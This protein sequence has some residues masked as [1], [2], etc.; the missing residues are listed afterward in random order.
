MMELSKEGK[1]WAICAEIVKEVLGSVTALTSGRLAECERRAGEV[2]A[3]GR[4]EYEA[5]EEERR[6]KE[7]EWERERLERQAASAPRADPPPA[8]KYPQSPPPYDG[9]P[10]YMGRRVHWHKTGEWLP[11]EQW[12]M[13]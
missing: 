7:A 10:G 11:A 6:R 9:T 8:E 2:I 4:A 1:L 5:K 12:S 13:A 3:V